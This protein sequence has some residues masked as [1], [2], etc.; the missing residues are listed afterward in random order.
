MNMKISNK[1][2]LNNLIEEVI[3]KMAAQDSWHKSWDLSLWL[4]NFESKRPYS[5]VNIFLLSFLMA[6]RGHKA[7]QFLTFNQVKKIGKKVKKGSK[8]YPVFFWSINKKEKINEDGEKELISIPFVK[9]Y[10]VFNIEDIEGI[11]IKKTKEVIENEAIALFVKKIKEKVTFTVGDPAFNGAGDFI[12]MPPVKDFESEEEYASTLFHELTHWTGHKSR[13]NRPMSYC[14]GSDKYAFE[15]AIAEF[16]AILLANHFGIK[17]VVV[18]DNSAAYINGWLQRIITDENKIKIF[19]R[20]TK[21]AV[22]A[23]EY[24]LSIVEETDATKESSNEKI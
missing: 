6:S 14:F 17:N 20:A 22:S 9:K 4:R 13:L 7:N 21:E 10:N 11:E 8:S 2:I 19:Y 23:V 15:E 3:E 18:I 16:G 12:K 5:G 1:T 24:L